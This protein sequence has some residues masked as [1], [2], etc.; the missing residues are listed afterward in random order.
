MIRMT[1][2]LDCRSM[3]CY[4]CSDCHTSFLYFQQPGVTED[5]IVVGR[6]RVRRRCRWRCG[7]RA[8]REQQPQLGQ[9]LQLVGQQHLQRRSAYIYVI[10]MSLACRHVVHDLCVTVYYM[11]VLC[12]VSV[13]AR[14]QAL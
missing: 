2:V 1:Y 5:V 7:Q 6:W 4:G 12:K 8:E 9:S 10:I 14:H 3:F 11:Y 13:A